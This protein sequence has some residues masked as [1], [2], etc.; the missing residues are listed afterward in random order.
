MDNFTEQQQ[1][2]RLWYVLMG[3]VNVIKKQARELRELMDKNPDLV[4]KLNMEK[5]TELKNELDSLHEI[6]FP[7]R[8]YKDG[9]ILIPVKD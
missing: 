6:I 2:E 8:T 3:N 7:I 5:F 1:A 9:V 4:E